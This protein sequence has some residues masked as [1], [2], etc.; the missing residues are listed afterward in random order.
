M[1]PWPSG[2]ARL[3]HLPPPPN[4]TR[5]PTAPHTP[6]NAL[7]PTL[8]QVYASA[9]QLE[10]IAPTQPGAAP[11]PR[12]APA[13]E[14]CQQQGGRAAWGVDLRQEALYFQA[15]D[16]EQLAETTSCQTTPAGSRAAS[17]GPCTAPC[18][19]GGDLAALITQEQQEQQQWGQGAHAAPAPRSDDIARHYP[20]VQQQ[21][22][23]YVHCI[24]DEHGLEPMPL[25]E[26][27]QHTA[28]CGNLV[29]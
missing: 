6:Q 17:P 16:R 28:E 15:V 22:E 14:V 4:H 27:F 19:G 8:P 1:M 25:T 9:T 20:R 13:T 24:K 12:P 29:F 18:G 10:S 5:P 3:R 23:R 21:Y 11:S 2:T 26:F 7:P